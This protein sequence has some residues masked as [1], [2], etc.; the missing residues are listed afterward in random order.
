MGIEILSGNGESKK[1][2]PGQSKDYV[3]LLSP[4][5]APRRMDAAKQRLPS[6]F[7]QEEGRADNHDTQCRA[8]LIAGAQNFGADPMSRGG[9]RWDEWQLHPNIWSLESVWD[10]VELFT[11]NTH[12]T[13]TANTSPWDLPSKWGIFTGNHTVPS[14]E[15]ESVLSFL[16]SLLG[17]G[18][19]FSTRRSCI[20]CPVRALAMYVQRSAALHDQ[21][22]HD[23]GLRSPIT[24]HR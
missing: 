1:S 4:Y 20:L 19:A 18:L 23:Q 14:C 16:H 8:L 12:L 17:E 15:V 3:H 2:G 24:N 13:P 5:V 11:S 7:L 9:P 10:L 6:G 21:G 22:L